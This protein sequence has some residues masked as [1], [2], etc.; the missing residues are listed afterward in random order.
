MT[1]TRPYPNVRPNP[2]R[3][4]W[5]ANWPGGIKPKYLGTFDTAEEARIEVLT[6]QAEH[7]EARAA[8]YRAE[9]KELLS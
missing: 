1:E 4:R 9:I 6:V 8:R 5:Q 3:T 2:S 7:L